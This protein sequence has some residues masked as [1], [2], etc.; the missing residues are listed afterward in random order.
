MRSVL[1]Q[2]GLSE[3]IRAERLHTEWAELVGP[4]IAARTRP[5][6]ISGSTLVVEVASSSWL[7]EL[8]LLR[9]QILAGLL[10]RI[11]EPRLFGELSFKLAGR[12]GGRPAPSSPRAVASPPTVATP[13]RAATG[14][15]REQIAREVDVIDDVELRA[16]IARV[17]IDND[18]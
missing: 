9:A 18:R 17:R 16:L 2:H 10:E 1:A 7:H 5:G 12:S 6:G 4:R 13:P 11:G 8:N 15:A 14:L 3:Q